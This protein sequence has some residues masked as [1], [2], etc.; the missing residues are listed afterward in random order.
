VLPGHLPLQAENLSD[1]D[2]YALSAIVRLQLSDTTSLKTTVHADSL[3]QLPQLQLQQ[4]L[5]PGT[6]QQQQQRGSSN[7][8]ACW[9]RLD[10]GGSLMLQLK[11]QLEWLDLTA[12]L[13]V[14]EPSV[15][16]VRRYSRTPLRLAVDLAPNS[17]ST[18]RR[19]KNSGKL[20]GLLF[21]V[22]L[23][24]A[25]APVEDV[26]GHTAAA[27]GRSNA[28]GSTAAAAAEHQ[29]HGLSVHC[30]GA[31]A[32]TADKTIWEAQQKP[33]QAAAEVAAAQHKRNKQKRQQQQ[34]AVMSAGAA[35]LPVQ[36]LQLP[37]AHHN[38]VSS[39]NAVAAAA[40]NTAAAAAGSA[41]SNGSSGTTTNHNKA[42]Q[43][44]NRN[45]S[46]HPQTGKAS[47]S[48]SSRAASSKHGSS[49]K[50]FLTFNG[51]E[52]PLPLCSPA[53]VQEALQV[54][55]Q[56]ASVHCFGTHQV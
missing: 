41:L 27:A 56:A 31:V 37:E 49:K 23:H 51:Q 5:F 26:A 15:E 16:G 11:Q 1:P 13:A 44:G 40:S 32:V 52:I 30:Q 12:D 4:R 17:S 29:Q 24:G 33:W 46:H 7:K 10:Q 50:Q 20:K 22:G 43:G 36:P 39:S 42:G 45:K 28:G 35:D 54:R 34:Q 2:N 18:M 47:S 53:T 14:N 6:Q 25:V 8:P 38:S 19:M 48:S 55:C 21:R 9:S 3:Q